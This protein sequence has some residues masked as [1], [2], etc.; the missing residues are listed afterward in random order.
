MNRPDWR[1]GRLWWS[2]AAA[3]IVVLSALAATQSGPAPSPKKER[4]TATRSAPAQNSRAIRVADQQSA[5]TGG[6]CPPN[7]TYP[8]SPTDHTQYGVPFTADVLDGTVNVGY[9]EDSGGPGTKPLTNMPWFPWMLHVTGLSG[10]VSGCVP[11][12]GLSLAVQP[13]NLQINTNGYMQGPDNCTTSQTGCSLAA[14]SSATFSFT[15]I[16]KP[17]QTSL[18]L[19]LFGDNGTAAGVTTI[20]YQTNPATAS[21]LQVSAPTFTEEYSYPGTGAPKNVNLSASSPPGASLN[22]DIYGGTVTVTNTTA[23]TVTSV[24]GVESA[25][26]ITGPSTLGPGASGIYDFTFEGSSYG[27]LPDQQALPLTFSGEGPTGLVYGYGIAYFTFS[28]LNVTSLE[29]TAATVNG[30]PAM[31]S[32]GPQVP[33]G[34]VFDGTVTLTNNTSTT[35]TGITGETGQA[36]QLLATVG[37]SG[38]QEP[39]LVLGGFSLSVAATRA[40]DATVVGARPD[41][42]GATPVGALDSTATASAAGVLSATNPELACG[43]PVSTK[44]TT[45]TSTVVPVSPAGDP[46]HPAGS[47]WTVQGEP[48]SGA[49]QGATARLVSNSFP[50][51]VPEQS[52]PGYTQTCGVFGELFNWEIGGV[53]PDGDFY[54]CPTCSTYG[55]TGPV[56]AGAGSGEVQ[57]EI[58]VV[59]TSVGGLPVCE[60][61][62]TGPTACGS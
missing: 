54:N 15:G 25:G 61:S 21:G 4:F 22:P 27:N 49:L 1:R 56:D 20:H 59:I 52:P 32:P 62:K 14:D 57:V 40:L 9:N 35:V 17:G 18:P 43:A 47:Q 44:V 53:E 33:M 23:S 19:D 13:S 60:A 12:P 42:F 48:I 3:A 41:A 8:D 26:F 38:D 45:G 16:A 28:S 55:S 11:L 29:I 2:I 31:T 30:Q 5:T 58:D 34:S 37:V 6:S 36:V 7:A 46:P 50:L 24:T 51:Q 39:P 10:T